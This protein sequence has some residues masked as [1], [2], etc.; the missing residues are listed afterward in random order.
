MPAHPG[1]KKT[2][3]PMGDDVKT[4][5]IL[6]VPV[7][8]TNLTDAAATVINWAREGQSNLVCVRDV[9][10]LMLSVKDARMMEIQHLAGMVT[11][12][13]MP[14]VWVGRLRGHK[15]ISRVSGADLMD[16]ICRQSID[17]GVRH[18]FYGGQQGV[19]DKVALQLT[20]SYP[21]IEVVGT[22]CPPFRPLTSTEEQ[23]VQQAI[24]LSGANIVWV[25][26]S[27]PKQEYWMQHFVS[28]L[29]G[30]TLI[31]VGA[32]F[33]F[34]AGS[35]TRA[36][37]WMRESGFEWLHRL[38]SEPRRLWRRYLLLAPE[39]VVRIAAEQLSYFVHRRTQSSAGKEPR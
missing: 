12:D 14:L 22:C 17:N 3:V 2:R 35:K 9:H 34:H 36:P 5:D 23:E 19:A 6:G 38:A 1:D 37:R 16:E 25:G 21:G 8:I 7:S 30:V 29:Q 10:G 28:R 26:I 27:T 15:A 32:A 13:G 18:Y 24:E 20:N 4:V 33:D 31:G 11:P 39:F